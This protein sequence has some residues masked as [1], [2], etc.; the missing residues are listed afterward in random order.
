MLIEICASN[1][2]MSLQHQLN[3]DG[4]DVIV[5]PCLDRCDRC[6]DYPYVFADGMLV[7]GPDTSTVIS[8]IQM[9]RHMDT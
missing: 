7:E 4:H 2:M 5:Y 8:M 6:A 9:L 3:M 1:E